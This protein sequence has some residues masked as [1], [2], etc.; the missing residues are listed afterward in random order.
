MKKIIYLFSAISMMACSNLDEQDST[1]SVSEEPEVKVVYIEN[2][3]ISDAKTRGNEDNLAF[4]FSSMR[5]YSD[6]KNKISNMDEVQRSN[7]LKQFGVK[8]LKELELIADDELEMIGNTALN[9]DDFRQKYE[10]YKQKYSGILISN[11]EDSSDLSLYAPNGDNID[12]YIANINH[13]FV[14]NNQIVKANLEPKVDC[15]MNRVNSVSTPMLSNN[16]YPINS[17]SWSPKSGKK[18]Y[19]EA[20]RDFQEVTFSAHARKK[21]WYGWKNDPHR[22][23]YFCASLSNFVYYMAGVAGQRVEMGNPLSMYVFENGV[24]NGFSTQF[25]RAIHTNFGDVNGRVLLW[26]D[27]TVEYDSDGKM[28]KKR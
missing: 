9:E 26:T 8:T 7:Y 17:G 19:F 23:Y 24:N 16:N 2:N 18:V 11:N 20:K 14:I 1:S 12:T 27:M 22:T 25:G 13:Q 3:S 21:M 15:V 28:Q 6:F 4:S 5:A 10:A